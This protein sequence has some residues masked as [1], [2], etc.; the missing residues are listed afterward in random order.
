MD[1]LAEVCADRLCGRLLRTGVAIKLG[2]REWTT[3]LNEEKRQLMHS[4][5]ILAKSHVPDYPI[6]FI[7]VPWALIGRS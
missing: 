1:M 7:P 4:A 2:C 5:Q 6:G 3:T